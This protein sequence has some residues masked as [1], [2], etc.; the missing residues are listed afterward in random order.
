MINK[1]FSLTELWMSIVIVSLL[2]A[3]SLPLFRETFSALQF[4]N[5]ANKIV[6]LLRYAQE[7]A[8]TR[9]KPYKMEVYKEE[10]R[11][12]LIFDEKREEGKEFKLAEGYDLATEILI[13]VFNPVGGIEILNKEMDPLKGTLLKSAFRLK[14]KRGREAEIEIWSYSGN[15]LYRRKK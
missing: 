9:N 6:S 10:K 3:I 13:L 8:V 12:V 11:L 15:V 7:L 14:D 4:E 1:G 2:V 5:S